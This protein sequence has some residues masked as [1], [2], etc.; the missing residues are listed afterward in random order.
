MAVALLHAAMGTATVLF[1]FLIGRAA[2]GRRLGLLAAAVV[3]L[4]PNLVFNVPTYTLELAFIFWSTAALA[5]IATHDWSSGPPS[6]RRLLAFG[7]V[8]G[9][10][11]LTRPFS[12]PFVLGLALAMVVIRAGWRRTFTAV[13]WTMLPVVVLLTPWTVRNLDALHSFVPV[14]TNLGD[15]ACLDRSM[16]ADGG[17]RWA[18]DGCADPALPEVQR[19]RENIGKAISFVVHHPVKE[20]ELM[21]KRLGRMLEHDHSGLQEAESVNGEVLS[22]G[23]RHIAIDVADGYFWIVMGAAAFGVVGLFRRGARRPERVLVAVALVVLLLLPIELWG[24]VRFHIPA[25]AFAAIAAA[26]APLAFRSQVVG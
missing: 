3:A 16:E 9:L 17:F 25:L 10:S 2:L 22:P 26:A 19:N 21:G 5:V 8:L 6:T 20:L 4:F 1:V 13:A 24:N 18:V 14:S 15:T 23:L 7:T 12:I 11:V